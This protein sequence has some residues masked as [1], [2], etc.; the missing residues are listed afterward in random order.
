MCPPTAPQHKSAEQRRREF[1]EGPIGKSE[2]NRL[3]KWERLKKL[4]EMRKSGELPWT[5]VKDRIPARIMDKIRVYLADIE[6]GAE[7]GE[8][9]ITAGV[10]VHTVRAWRRRYPRFVTYEERALV[11][12]TERRKAIVARE[13]EARAIE[14]K[15]RVVRRVKDEEGN[16]V[17]EVT[18][19]DRSDV[20]LAKMI[21]ALWPELKTPAVSITN[22]NTVTV[23]EEKRD[24]LRILQDPE[25]RAAL[26]RARDRARL[27]APESGDAGGGDDE[28]PPA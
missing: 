7:E 6:G 22:T 23:E 16:V 14:G 19:I 11:E 18:T 2:I 24:A 20:L 21:D 9:A 8:A 26:E 15:E 25:L 4:A 28:R 1:F 5:A 3:P 13:W 17:K 10:S 27:P 12:R